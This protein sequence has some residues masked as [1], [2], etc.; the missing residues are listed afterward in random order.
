MKTPVINGI[1]LKTVKDVERALIE[2][3]GSESDIEGAGIF[4]GLMP[5]VVGFTYDNRVIYDY[6]KI[7]EVFQERDGM[8]EEEAIEY[9][10]FNVLR[11]LPYM[12]RQP[13]IL[14]PL[15]CYEEDQHEG[16]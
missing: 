14:Y 10:D 5:A 1:A 4:D 16:D 15:D 11:T 2:H 7:L 12:G 8:T 9:V 6:E 3:A 13:V